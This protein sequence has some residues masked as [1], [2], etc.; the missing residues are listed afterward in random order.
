MR[1]YATIFVA[2]GLSAIAY[3]DEPATKPAATRPESVAITGK[4]K[5]DSPIVKLVAVDRLWAD[6]LKVSRE[7][8]AVSG[9]DEFVY[10]AK[11]EKDGAFSIAKLIPTR[12]Y[13]LIAWTKAGGDGDAKIV[14]WEGVTMDYHRPIM[15]DKEFSADDRKWIE[16]F[17]SKTPGF[18]DRCRP[19]WIA[20]DHK[21]ATVAV[22]LAR[23]QDFYAAKG[24]EVIYRT[25][26]WYFENL[27]GGWEKDKNTERVIARWRGDGAKLP[28]WQIV[29]QLGG[30]SIAADGTFPK[31][32]ITL[33]E[34]P[35]PK[36]GSIGGLTK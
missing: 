25:E 19:L 32:E 7:E 10:A 33:P 24:G 9:G 21:H 26:L 14:R 15:P 36:R 13:D 11:L 29:P 4:I 20:A 17:I 8:A 22:E 18:Y 23:T 6:V 34:K 28:A 2:V 5:S 3:A 16:D 12:T 35:D 27:F 31:I 30:I 1:L